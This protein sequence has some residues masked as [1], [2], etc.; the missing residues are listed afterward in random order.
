MRIII[1]ID[2]FQ[3]YYQIFTNLSFTKRFKIKEK[4]EDFLW[5]L[6]QIFFL[7]IPISAEV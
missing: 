1:M 4:Q 6:F 7:F 5:Y 2:K 3:I